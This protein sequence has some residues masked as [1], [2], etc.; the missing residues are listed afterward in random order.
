VLGVAIA[1]VHS[2][3]C[4]VWLGIPA[5]PYPIWRRRLMLAYTSS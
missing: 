2:S 5:Y 4:C 3:C 1:V